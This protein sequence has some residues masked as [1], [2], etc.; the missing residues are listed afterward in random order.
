M[1]GLSGLSRCWRVG[2]DEGL[3]HFGSWGHRLEWGDCETVVGKTKTIDLAN[4]VLYHRY[5]MDSF[6]SYEWY[7]YSISIYFDQVYS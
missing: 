1:E 2:E 4:I 3:C 6:L 5:L 7:M